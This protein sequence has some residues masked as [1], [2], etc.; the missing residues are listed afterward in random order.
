MKKS[1]DFINNN[2]INI[3]LKIGINTDTKIALSQHS[4]VSQKLLSR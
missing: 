4:Y 1:S 2:I 3:Q